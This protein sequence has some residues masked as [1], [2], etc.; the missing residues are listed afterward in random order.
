MHHFVVVAFR[1][2]DAALAGS[3]NLLDD[4]VAA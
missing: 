4:P 1:L 3:F 2:A